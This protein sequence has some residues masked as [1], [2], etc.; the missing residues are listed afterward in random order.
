MKKC[1]SIIKIFEKVI[2]YSKAV[3]YLRY[4]KVFLT[5]NPKTRFSDMTKTLKS[6][7]NI[8]YFQKTQSECFS[9][10]TIDP[11]RFMKL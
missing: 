10:K 2:S 11:I 1:I 7:K 5:A 9:I 4:K 8:K 3:K 6:H